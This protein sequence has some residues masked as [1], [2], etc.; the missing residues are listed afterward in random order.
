MKRIVI[1]LALALLVYTLT[2]VYSAP[3][4]TFDNE[5]NITVIF[6]YYS[7]NN[8]Y[9]SDLS[10]LSSFQL[11]DNNAQPGDMIYFGFGK[12]GTTIPVIP[13]H[14]LYF[15]ISTPLQGT[16]IQ[17]VWEYWNDSAKAWKTIPNLVDGT[18]QFTQSG[19]VTFPIPPNW[20]Y[21]NTYYWSVNN[22]QSLWIRV[23]LASGTVTNG[24]TV[25]QRVKC[26]DYTLTVSNYP[27]INFSYIYSTVQKN[28]WGVVSQVNTNIYTIT[29]NIKFINS[30]LYSSK[31]VIIIGT[32]D[33]PMTIQADKHSYLYFGT[34]KSNGV[35]ADGSEIYLYTRYVGGATAFLP[36]GNFYFY[37][38]RF[39][40]FYGEVSSPSFPYNVS[41]VDS[42]FIAD[43]QF[44]FNNTSVGTI[45]RLLYSVPR[46]L[47]IYGNI[48]I[49]QVIL[50]SSSQGIIVGSGSPN[51]IR[52]VVLASNQSLV[53]RYDAWVDLIDC[54]ITPSQIQNWNPTGRDVWVRI[55]YSF[56]LKLIDKNGNPVSGATVKLY[57]TYG[58]L[59]FSLSTNSTGQIPT[60][61]VTT[62]ITWWNQSE[63]WSVRH[64]KYYTPFTL[65]ISHPSY[66]PI[67]M[68]WNIQQPVNLLLP[69]DPLDPAE[70]FVNTTRNLYLPKDVVIIQGYV[71]YENVKQTGL[72][73]NVTVFKPDGTK[74]PLIQ[75]RDDGQFPD[76]VAND[77]LYAGLFT[78]TSKTGTYLVNASTIFQSGILRANWTF[79]VDNTGDLILSVNNTLYNKI[80]GVN[81]SLYTRLNQLSSQLSGVNSSLS[82][83]IKG[84]NTTLYNKI[85]G[86]NSSIYNKIVSVNNTLYL[87][88]NT[89]NSNLLSING[90]LSSKLNSINSTLYGKIVAINNTLY[91][92]INDLSLKLTSINGTLYNTIVNVNKTLYVKLSDVNSSLYAEIT[93]VNNTLY[94][95]ISNISFNTTSLE[96][97]IASVNNTLYTK[98]DSVN[99]TLYGK[100]VQVN[101]SLYLKVNDVLLRVTSINGSLYNAISS[102]NSTIQL[103]LTQE[104]STH[105][106]I[107][108]KLNN[109]NLT[110]YGKLEAIN[111]TLVLRI[112]NASAQIQSVNN[113]VTS[114]TSTVTSKLSEIKDT[115]SKINLNFTAVLNKIDQATS[116]ILD[117]L[118]KI[119]NQ[120]RQ[121]QNTL[122]QNNL[123]LPP[124]ILW[125]IV[126]QVFILVAIFLAVKRQPSAQFT[127]YLQPPEKH[128]TVNIVFAIVF[129]AL[130]YLLLSRFSALLPIPVPLAFGIVTLFTLIALYLGVKKTLALVVLLGLTVYLVWTQHIE[131]GLPSLPNIPLPII[132]LTTVFIIFTIIYIILRRRK[133]Q[134]EVVV[135]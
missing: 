30:T 16:G 131:I 76:T 20:Y 7:K 39:T 75:L 88:I 73:I 93:A 107:L 71:L 66:P 102:T 24:G 127:P 48:S 101:N 96:N 84:V 36:L 122:Q 72:T 47:Y 128:K 67:I 91:L 2:I 90:S 134:H 37:G 92:K 4:I 103:R 95:K 69:I 126:V 130:T 1:L 52:N 114:S 40:R 99:V 109:I 79:I 50:S 82:T 124:W 104:E 15:S 38:S 86:V 41:I 80:L 26:H 60:Q 55:R 111:N 57:D 81:S 31:E 98:L 49:N 77:G 11:F 118:S 70:L 135:W 45:T 100:I 87:K 13:W 6:R 23:R 22:V 58:N 94:L 28:G 34:L 12:V 132:S 14:D 85:L 5:Q 46:Y 125:L 117:T 27:T 17:L 18:K 89:V 105:G 64:E 74:S 112:E 68:K 53:R 35:G 65:V 116:T 108:S 59:V 62:Y 8:T 113:T 110:L 83:Q 29:S 10:S 3:S 43:T 133:K 121:L 21:G 32:P 106:D 9:S 33:K 129:L 56:N 19:W 115:L 61:Y 54:S 78:D 63:N 123:T 97:K 51:T 119:S 42:Q 25:N 120:I 44:Y